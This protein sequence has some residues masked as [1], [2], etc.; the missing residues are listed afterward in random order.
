[1]C[2]YTLY[3]KKKNLIKSRTPT[4]VNFNNTAFRTYQTPHKNVSLVSSLKIIRICLHQQLI[5]V[6]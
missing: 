4:T 2:E 3:I 5:V 6:D 1:M